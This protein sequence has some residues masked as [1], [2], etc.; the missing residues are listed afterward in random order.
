[1]TRND[2]KRVEDWKIGWIPLVS[3]MFFSNSESIDFR[4]LRSRGN[5]PNLK[6][7]PPLLLGSR[8]WDFRHVFCSSSCYQDALGP[9]VCDVSTVKLGPG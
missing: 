8:T 9:Y 3:N 5:A 2:Q 7:N 4:K 6:S 1:M